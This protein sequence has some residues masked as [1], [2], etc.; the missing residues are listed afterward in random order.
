MDYSIIHN[1]SWVAEINCSIKYIGTA[2]GTLSE[3][4]YIVFRK[5]DNSVSIHAKNK[6]KP[7]NY[8]NAKEIKI[9]NNQIICI[10]KKEKLIITYTDINWIK[11]LNL[12]SHEVVIQNTEK[13]LMDKLEEFIRSNDNEFINIYREYP[14][15]KGKIDVVVEYHDKLKLYEGK[16]RKIITKDIYQLYRYSTCISQNHELY[17]VGPSIS[18]TAIKS[19]E[20]NKIKFIQLTW[21]D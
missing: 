5:P 15:E 11:P 12:S 8:I 16:R 7:R 20:E 2:V 21:D 18:S 10:N 19:C 4:N 6:I 14:T 1:D 17:L 3:G 13:Q 9:E